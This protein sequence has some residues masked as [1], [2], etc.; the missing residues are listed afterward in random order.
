MTDKFLFEYQEFMTIK[1]SKETTKKIEEKML[2]VGPFWDSDTLSEDEK[3]SII[4]MCNMMIAKRFNAHPTFEFYIDNIIAL[5]RDEL[6]K[7]IFDDWIKSINYYVQK[8]RTGY[9]H[10]YFNASTRFFNTHHIYEKSKKIWKVTNAKIKIKIID[11]KPIYSFDT[12]NLIGTTGADS[13]YIWHTTGDYHPLRERWEGN[14]GKL[15]WTRVGLAD[16]V[17]YAV[18]QDYKISLKSAIW[19]ADSVTFYDKRNF[20]FGLLG[21]VKDKFS[22]TKQTETSRY[23]SFSSYGYDYTINEIYENVDYQGGYSLKGRQMIGSGKGR[24]KA[25]FIFKHNGKNFVYAGSDVF[26]IQKDKILSEKVTVTIYLESTDTITGEVSVDSIYHPGLSLYY[27]NKKKNL[28][29][30]RKDEGIAQTP[31]ADSYHNISLFVEELNWKLGEDY[32]DMKSI[33][34]KGI[35]SKAYFESE[36]Y[37]SKNR[38]QKLQGMDRQNPVEAVYN[39]VQEN[40]YY[41]FYAEDFG[42][43]MHMSK[44]TTI[45]Y[46]MNLASKGFLLYDFE[47]HYVIVKPSVDVYVMAHRGQT[48]YDVIS[49]MSETNGVI[50][51][52]SLNLV[53]ND[54]ILQGVRTVFLSDSQDVR[55]FPRNGRVQLK[56]NRDFLFAGRITA[57][58]F[59]IHAKDV[60]FSYDKFKLEMPSI[61]SLSFKVEAFELDKYGERPL[62]RIKNVIEDLKGYILIDQPNNKSGIQ[63]FPEYPILNSESQSYVY[64]DKTEIYNKVYKRDKFYY[65]LESFEIDSLDDFRTDGLEFNG[66]LESAGIFPDIITPLKV[67]RDYSVGFVTTTGDAGYSLYGG[68][69]MFNDTIKLSNEGLQGRGSLRYLTSL[70]I[71]NDLIFFPDSTDAYLQSYKIEEVKSGVEYPPVIASN[72]DMHFEPYN[73]IM[74]VTTREEQPSIDMY[75]NDA[76]I[77]GSLYLTS[78][79]LDGNGLIKIKNAELESDLF[80]FKNRTFVSDSCMFRLKTLAELE[81]TDEFDELEDFNEHEQLAFAT[82]D[83]FVANVDFNERKAEFESKSDAKLVEFKENMYKCYMDKFTWYM[84]NEKVEFST[85]GD[86]MAQVKDKTIKEV[87]DIAL[88]GTRFISTHPDQDSL[89]FISKR[90]VYSQR[91]KEIDAYGVPK[92]IVADAVIIPGENKLKIFAKAELEEIHEA[93]L[94]VNRETKYHELYKGVF[95]VEGK[96]SYHGR[97]V[98][99][100]KDEDGW[101]QNILFNKIEVDTAGYTV[102]NAT[103]GEKDGFTLSNYFDFYGEITLVGAN[104]YL[105]FDGGTRID[106]NCDT[107][108]HLAIEFRTEIDPANISIPIDEEIKSIDGK[109]LYCGLNSREYNGQVYSVFMNDNGRRTDNNIIQSSGSL[110]FDKI[111]QEYRIASDEKLSQRSLPGN[112]ISLSRRDCALY[113]EGELN[114]AFKTGH[115][116]ATAYGK[117]RYFSREDSTDFSVS[118]PLNFYFNDKALELMATDLNDRMNMGSVDLEND[119]YKIMLNNKLGAE[120]SDKYTGQIITNGGEYRKVPKEL[121]STIFIS[122]VKMKYNPRTRSIVSTGDIGI[123]SLGKYQILKYVPGK[124]EI[125]NKKTGYTITIALNLGNKEYYYFEIKGSAKNGQVLAYSSNKEFITILKDSKADERKFN[126]KE[127]DAKFRY[128]LSTPVKYKRFMRIMKMKE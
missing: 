102:G 88:S 41:E 1:V 60:F 62:V 86:P 15:F 90:G 80:H 61:D 96:H 113:T 128:Y 94:L 48:D 8:R 20:S 34:Q 119:I 100:Y 111:S 99:D 33:Q 39:Y 6:N 43:Y 77:D 26:V 114:L 2:E 101:V 97:G 50:P 83:V 29:I 74:I 47:D 78:T 109:R 59:D 49:F 18:M 11:N 42:N 127:R 71:S 16:G 125:I 87:A 75:A 70:G 24:D 27:S 66:Y 28:S 69:A 89:S 44:E 63:D 31:F 79:K 25:F 37:F 123:S 58:R 56:K 65:T 22:F 92:L 36:N 116:Q 30:Y 120:L 52:A 117:A 124:I 112:Y 55:I 3:K 126:D 64:Y 68:K 53:N 122:D 67:M 4:Q 23:P 98:Y 54:I 51:N 14:G 5:K 110:V 104:R 118:I 76:T 91:K 108:E 13:T 40:G 57:G 103:I 12:V 107:L 82:T 95:I 17:V 38:Y 19:T 72:V 45:S 10:R 121:L 32:I 73:D 84:D 115:V 7:D 9:L 81:Q 46:L 35:D 21:G 105:I 85:K 106:H 93:E